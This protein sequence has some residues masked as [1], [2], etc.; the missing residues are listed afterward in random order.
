MRA[1][2]LFLIAAPPFSWGD[3]PPSGYE[4][5]R[6]EAM[7]IGISLIVGVGCDP[8]AGEWLTIRVEAPWH[9]WLK[10]CMIVTRPADGDLAWVADLP[11]SA[12][13]N[14]IRRVLAPPRTALTVP[15]ATNA[16]RC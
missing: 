15:R 6:A 12:S 13:A 1:V 8:P 16:G 5:M 11:A 7:R 14:D 3:A 2:M 4:E 9:A 10:P